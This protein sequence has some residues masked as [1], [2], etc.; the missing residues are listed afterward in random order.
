[1]LIS[2]GAAVNGLENIG[3]SPLASTLLS[4]DPNDLQIVQLLVQQDVDCTVPESGRLPVEF[5]AEIKPLQ[6]TADAVSYDSVAALQ[7]VEIVKLLIGDYNI[8]ESDG[9]V[10][11]LMRAT[12]ANN[13]ELVRYLLS[14]GAE[15]SIRSYDGKT[16][17]DCAVE[18][19][20]TEIAELLK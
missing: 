5:A 13:L 8:N 3:W 19:G 17:Y 18:K 9:G 15:K 11:L 12:K 4:Y 2:H 14:I 1:M 10:T 7:I 6:R 16:A 20:Y